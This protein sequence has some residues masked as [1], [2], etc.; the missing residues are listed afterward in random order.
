[1]IRSA[2]FGALSKKTECRVFVSFS[3]VRPSPRQITGYY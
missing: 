3:S 1:L 2:V